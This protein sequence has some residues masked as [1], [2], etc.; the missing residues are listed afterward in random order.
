MSVH[1]IELNQLLVGRWPLDRRRCRPT[2]F[3]STSSRTQ[4][5]IPL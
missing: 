2:K 1:Q 5:T 3:D 4:Q